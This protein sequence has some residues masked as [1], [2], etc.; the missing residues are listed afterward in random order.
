MIRGKIGGKIIGV[1]FMEKYASVRFEAEEVW[2]AYSDG[3]LY[4]SYTTTSKSGKRGTNHGVSPTRE[5]F[6]AAMK[7]GVE[8]FVSPQ[9]LK[10]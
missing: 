2:T 5:E 8:L 3:R 9:Y 1:L 4:G 7:E 10:E 6:D